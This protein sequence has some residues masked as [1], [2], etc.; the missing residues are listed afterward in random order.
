MWCF[1]WFAEIAKLGIVG[2]CALKKTGET[3]FELTKMG[4]R[5]SARGRK[6]GEALLRR[7]IF[8]ANRIGARQL[9]LLTS[10]KCEAAIHLYEKN[11]FVHSKAIMRRYGG[12][13]DRCDVAMLYV[14]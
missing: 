11:G 8:E 4:V 12:R 9:Y 14:A 5:A 1:I 7:V 3:E 10:A 6:V 13:Y 2:A